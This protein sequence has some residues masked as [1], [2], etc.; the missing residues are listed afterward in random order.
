MSAFSDVASAYE[1]FGSDDPFYAVLTHDE[2]R[3][4]RLDKTEFYE[5]GR[6]QIATVFQ[7]AER[8][9]IELHHGRACDFGCGVGRLTNA[10]A[11]RFEEVVGVDV[12]STMV[13]TAVA[14]CQHE[15]CRF[16]VNKRQD[17]QLFGD[18]E[19]D[20]I[21]SDITI[22]H[23]PKPASENYI[24]EFLRILRPGGL[25][26]FLVPDGPDHPAGS[27]S[28]RIDRFHREKFR[29]WLKRV[30]GKHPVQLH[31]IPRQ[32]VES[33]VSEQGGKL[34]HTEVAP[35]F[36]NSTRRYLPLFYWVQRGRQK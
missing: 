6:E 5:T 17:L 19:F 25:A 9:K 29:P 11:T 13:E 4:D 28:A 36:R 18:A 33:L 20:F 26:V 31:S 21:Y 8:L 22:Q 34:L 10:L 2:Y 16:V 14:H 7:T 23:I 35:R 32:R 12:S 30:R 15:N 24:R 3:K 1:A 27:L